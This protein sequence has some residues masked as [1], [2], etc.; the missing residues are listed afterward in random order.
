[1]SQAKNHEFEILIQEVF[2]KKRDVTSLCKHLMFM[3]QVYTYLSV[4]YT[5]KLFIF[6]H[7]HIPFIRFNEKEMNSVE[8][9]YAHARGTK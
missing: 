3:K 9:C 2:M 4:L 6:F 8:T 1:M 5:Q 7:I